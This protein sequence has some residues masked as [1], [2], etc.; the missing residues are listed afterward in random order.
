MSRPRILPC[1]GCEDGLAKL[2]PSQLYVCRR[3]PGGARGLF[4][5]TCAGCR[6]SNA[7][8]LN[9]ITSGEFHR[10]PERTL[11]QLEA[12]GHET[13]PLVADFAMGGA[14]PDELA[15]GLFNAGLAPAHARDLHAAGLDAEELEALPAR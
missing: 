8:K 9:S 5:Y 10:L 2:G 15:R 11:E 7:E 1:R 12:L 14:F 4:T 6:R 13:A 3:W